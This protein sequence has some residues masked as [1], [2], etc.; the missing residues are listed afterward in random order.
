MAGIIVIAYDQ[1]NSYVKIMPET[2]K[3]KT[4]NQ[5]MIRHATVALTFCAM[6]LGAAVADSHEP[7]KIR[8]VIVTGHQFPG[9]K[10]RETTL[11]LEDDLKKDPRFDVTS[12][13]DVEFLASE[14]LHDYNVIILNYCNWEQPEGLSSKAKANFVRFL[15]QGGGLTIIHFTNGAFHFTLPKAEAADWPQWRTNICRRVWHHGQG[16]SGHDPYG[17]FRIDIADPQHPIGRGLK[18]FET[19]DEL[20]F[21]QHGDK[22]IHVIATAKSKKTGNNEPMAFVHT[23]GKGRVFQTVLG[24]D[25]DS[26]RTKGTAE[27]IRRGSAWAAGRS[28]VGKVY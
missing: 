16:K 17:P 4:R 28:A 14:K 23:Y 15:K 13:P 27:L 5:Q 6:L 3:D 12:I 2:V 26:L 21:R 24:H 19:V 7:D 20:Y 9:H 11:A 10:W 25:A 22:P 1:Q 8:L 18:S